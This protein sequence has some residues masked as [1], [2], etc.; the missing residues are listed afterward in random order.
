MNVNQPSLREKIGQMLLVGFDG[1]N[2]ETDSMLAKAIESQAIGGVILFDYNY[3]TQSFD[4]NI[5]SPEQLKALCSALNDKQKQHSALPLYIGIDYEGGKV[6]RLKEDK[7]FAKTIDAKT[8]GSLSP[9]EAENEALKMVKTLKQAGINLNFAPVVDLDIEGNPIIS[10]LG[11]AYS[12]RPSLVALYA[13]ILIRAQYT[14]G[15]QSVLKHYPGHGSSAKD[16]HLDMVDV[17][18]T[19]DANELRPYHNLLENNSFCHFVMTAHIINRKLDSEGL[20]ATMSKPMLDYLRHEVHFDG[21]IISDDMQMKAISDHYDD[22][23]ALIKSINAGCDMLIYGNQ[24]SQ[25][26]VSPM[27]LI[28]IVESAVN[29][30]EIAQ[31]RIDEAYQRI[32]KL[33]RS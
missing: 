8:F 5:E 16:S 21:I 18:D 20:P 2:F 1:L 29:E 33:K 30:G 19:W 15:I 32:V 27:A 9:A 24:L 28:D 23:E 14:H 17:T 22:K 13:D 25:E 7:G 11:R 4:K 10:E 12:N 26:P 31:E 3:Q 6:N